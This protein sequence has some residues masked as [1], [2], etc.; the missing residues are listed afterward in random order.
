MDAIYVRRSIRR[1]TTQPVT[2]E[3]LESF[4]KAGMNAPSAGDEQPWQFIIIDDR[5][6]MN[7]IMEIHRHAEML[8]TAQAAILVCGET[9]RETHPGYWTQDCSAATENILLEIASQGCGAVWCGVYPRLGRVEGLRT[10]LGIPES[11][12]PFALIPV[13]YPAEQKP[14]KNLFHRDRIRYNTWS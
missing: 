10:L 3:Q 11:V 12:I 7:R 1:F 13:G 14:A 9:S 4:V 6:T 8:A 5:P 2:R